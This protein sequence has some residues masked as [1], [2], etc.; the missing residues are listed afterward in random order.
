MFI[1]T[2]YSY[3]LLIAAILSG[4]FSSSTC[5]SQFL[6]ELNATKMQLISYASYE[7]LTLV[8]FIA[9][10]S[11]KFLCRYSRKVSVVD[12]VNCKKSR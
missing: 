6:D 11:G 8:T 10:P 7:I 4:N 9:T 2:F 12:P 5:K 3:A 1:V